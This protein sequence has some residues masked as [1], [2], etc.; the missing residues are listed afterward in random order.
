MLTCVNKTLFKP[1]T[2]SAAERAFVPPINCSHD[3]SSLHEIRSGPDNM[4]ESYWPQQLPPS[5]FKYSSACRWRGCILALGGWAAGF[6]PPIA[7]HKYRV[8]TLVSLH[9][10][11][12]P[13]TQ[14]GPLA[15]A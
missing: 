9:R 15:I 12:S 10:L 4:Q 14:R 11:A 6:R 3:W 1:N 13:R 8:S 2:V 5:S 7:A